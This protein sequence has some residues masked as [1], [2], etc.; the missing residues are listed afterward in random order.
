MSSCY[1]YHFQQIPGIFYLVRA[2]NLD[3]ILRPVLNSLLSKYLFSITSSP[4]E[5]SIL[6]KVEKEQDLEQ[7]FGQEETFICPEQYH[8]L[9]IETNDPLLSEAGLLSEVTKIFSKAQIP[10]LCLSTYSWNYIY[11]PTTHHQE[12][13]QVINSRQ[14][15][16]HI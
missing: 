15:I 11:Y 12:L 2:E 14:D 4:E 6:L 5:T 10:I 7:L 1:N 3:Q 9:K 8:C 16:N 13:N